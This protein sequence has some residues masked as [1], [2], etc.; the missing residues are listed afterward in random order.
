M[1]LLR[2]EHFCLATVNG[3]S[4]AAMDDKN[5]KLPPVLLK[6]PQHHISITNNVLVFSAT[7]ASTHIR[8][9]KK[10]LQV[11]TPATSPYRAT[12]PYRPAATRSVTTP[13]SS[14]MSHQPSAWTVNRY[15]SRPRPGQINPNDRHRHHW[16]AIQDSLHPVYPRPRS[17]IQ[18]DY[19]GD[20]APAPGLKDNADIFFGPVGE[21]GLSMVCFVLLSLPLPL[22]LLPFSL[23]L[24]FNPSDRSLTLLHSKEQRRP[25]HPRPPARLAPRRSLRRLH[26]RPPPRLRRHLRAS[27]PTALEPRRRR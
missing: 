19:T 22:P 1:G 8:K 5:Q 12:I 23:S 24:P 11:L 9:Y 14:A 25:I 15:G 3:E 20:I 18:L 27:A 13:P 21:G 2:S 10:Y 6:N 16:N 4:Q 7:L 17:N 26:A